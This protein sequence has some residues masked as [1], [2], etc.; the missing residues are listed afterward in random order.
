MR[1]LLPTAAK[2]NFNI[3]LFGDSQIEKISEITAFN[4]KL[5]L[6]HCQLR[7]SNKSEANIYIAALI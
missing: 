3:S 2:V 5:E 4:E 1:Y 7:Y 6:F